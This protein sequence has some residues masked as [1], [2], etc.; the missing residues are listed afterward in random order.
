MPPHP[1]SNLEIQKYYQNEPR[2]NGVYSRNNLPKKIK[3]EA[4]VINLDEYEDVGT[5]WIA[6]F[7]NRNEIV[8]FD[9]FGVEH[10][11]EEIKEFIGNKN[12]KTNIFRV[13]ENNSIMCGYFCI[14]F[15]DFMLSG[16]K[17]NWFYKHVFSYDFFPKWRYNSEL[18]QRWMKLIKQTWLI[19][20]NTD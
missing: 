1:L 18:F 17:T 20:Q 8:Y 5:H 6:L 2:F 10:V 15:T 13:Q 4:Y 9:S 16:K 19:K 14:G 7:C 3:D 12:I 11:P